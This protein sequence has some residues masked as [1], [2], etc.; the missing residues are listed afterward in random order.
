MAGRL[1]LA[2]R[3]RL[4]AALHHE[5]YGDRIESHV[6]CHA[7]GEGIELGF[8]LAALAASLAPAREQLQGPDLEGYFLL[9]EQLRVRLPTSDDQAAL[10]GCQPE[11]AR[12]ALL[13]RCLAPDELAKR[14][15]AD[16]DQ[17]TLAR[18]EQQLADANPI[19]D[20]PLD[21]PCHACRAV[22][23]VRFDLPTYLLRA[24]AH[25]RRY[26]LREI[27]YVAHAYGWSLAEILELERDDRRRLVELIA[28]E[29]RSPARRS[30]P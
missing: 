6:R 22:Q 30:L 17:G 7:C 13:E 15:L 28:A 1:A 20:L 27:H 26:L 25:E 18:I 5:L 8:S 23:Q 11:R 2:D 29:R 4:L 9:P 14:T 21:I 24:L 12:L 3:D 19:V 10:L 16:L